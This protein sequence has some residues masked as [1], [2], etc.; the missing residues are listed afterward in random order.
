MK[1]VKPSK[2]AIIISTF[3]QEKLLEIN[4]NSILD[5]T[6]YKDYKIFLIDDSGKGEIGRKIKKKFKS[7]DVT[8][9]LENKGF[10]KSNNLGI[11]RA[12]KFYNPDYF[13]LLN[14]DTEVIDAD[15]LKKMVLEG[16]KDSQI[17]VLGCKIIY[18]DGSLQNV[19]GYI[20]KWE[21]AKELEGSRKKVFEVDH[22]MGAFML[23]KRE[24]INKVGYLDETY[25]PYLLED[26]DY[27][28]NVK[29]KGFKVVSVPYVSIIHKKGKSIDS[30]DKGEVMKVRMRNDIYF[31]RKNLLG[32]K[33]F[34]RLFIY[35]PMVAIFRKRKDEN[36][37]NLK[38][39]KLRKD[40]LRNLFIYLHSF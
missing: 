24:I 18:P 3:N 1:K 35:L 34:F 4:L 2:V 30:L 27:C 31:T 6:N 7:I 40:F 23:I 36:S 26:T 33:K 13:L 19:G 11:K 39:F 10:S 15:W 22:V 20:K 21:I 8:I 38:N 32:W 37:L 5:K 29:K 17:G 14:D 9:N 28:L 25:S 16:E 12:L